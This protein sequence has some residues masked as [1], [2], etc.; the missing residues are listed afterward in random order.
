MPSLTALLTT[1]RRWSTVAALAAVLAAVCGGPATAQSVAV[2]VNGEPITSFDVDQR[3]R[4]TQ[5]S[6]QRTPGRK[7][8]IEELID[9]R[10]KHQLLKR[11]AI[12]DVDKDVD[13]TFNGMA[14]RAGMNPKTFAEQLGRA[15]VGTATLKARI[16]AEI[17]WSQ[18][19]RGRY[20]SSFQFSDKDIRTQL[21]TR[22][23]DVKNLTGFDYTLRP[24]VFVVP[25][26]A[27]GA[28]RE[29]RRREAEALRSRFSSCEQG[30]KLARSL[31]EVAVRAPIVRSSADLSPQ[32]REILERTELGKLSA[33]EMTAQGVEVYA[34]CGKR[35]SSPDNAPGRREVREEM[36]SAQF[37]LKSDAFLKELRSQAMIEYR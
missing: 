5:V 25:R 10:L 28:L 19:V 31:R 24:I 29:A 34:L 3:I 21:E 2:M 22:N 20:S 18:V 14:R 8:V 15:N 27:D 12:P 35:A 26:G 11:F 13:N 7:E 16:K 6:T 23:P 37:K 1:P 4:L 9:E 36:A 17:I 32:L 30:V 33:P